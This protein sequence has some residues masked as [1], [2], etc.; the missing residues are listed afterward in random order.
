MKDKPEASGNPVDDDKLPNVDS[1]AT[2]RL[3][4]VTVIFN[5]Q[6]REGKKVKLKGSQPL[7]DHS[8]S[9]E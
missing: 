4:C 7:R 3:L 8:E 9:L 6:D 5:P 2:D 1:V